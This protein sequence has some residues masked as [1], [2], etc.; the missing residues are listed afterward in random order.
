M[1]ALTTRTAKWLDEFAAREGLIAPHRPACPDHTLSDSLCRIE[2]Q[3]MVI[4]DA[5]AEAGWPAQEYVDAVLQVINQA[6]S[7]N[8]S[9]KDS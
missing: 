8:P 9:G 1:K 4:A 2:N 3:M 5:F 6:T 7:D